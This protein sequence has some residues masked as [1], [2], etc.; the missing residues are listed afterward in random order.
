MR[1]LFY[2]THTSDCANHVAAW[3]SFS[4]RPAEHLTYMHTGIRNDWRLVEAVR[5]FEPEV[6]FCI[7]A[8]QGPGEPKDDTLRTVRSLAPLVNLCSDAADKPWHRVLELNRQR[9]LFDLQV[10]IDGA[11]EAPVDLA[12]LTPVSPRAFHR[13]PP[14]LRDIRCGFSG[15]VGRWNA[16]SE[17]VKALDWFGGLTVRRRDKGGDYSDHA[18]FMLRCK[19]LLNVS[20]TGSGNAHHIK[21]RVIEAGLAGCALLESEGSPIAEWFP[22]DCY[23]IYKDPREA[24]AMI[25]E[26]SDQTIA[27][28][29]SRLSEEVKSRYRPA[30]IYGEILDHVD[31]AKQRAAL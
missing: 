6:V 27:K 11:K 10:S 22:P 28:M 23:L 29:A 24:A 21:G 17:I 12:T 16:R 20:C 8:F 2:T 31:T 15:T 25:A 3:N 1:A 18:D 19:M 14:P 30:Q 13:L 7:G 4:I 5:K 26:L 9:G